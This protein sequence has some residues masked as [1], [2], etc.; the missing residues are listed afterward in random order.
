MD[1]FEMKKLAEVILYILHKT[2]TI[3][4]YHLFKILYFAERE[5]LAK[6]G[7]RITSDTFRYSVGSPFTISGDTRSLGW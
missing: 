5:H 2:R 4:Y 6:W 7:F 1:E 3:D